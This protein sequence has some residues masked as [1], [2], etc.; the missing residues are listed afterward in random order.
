[1]KFRIWNKALNKFVQPDEWYI[2]GDGKVFFH[3]IM[4]GDLIRAEDGVCVIQRCS[5]VK[6]KNGKEIWEGDIVHYDGG[7]DCGRKYSKAE[8]VFKQGEFTPIPNLATTWGTSIDSR[9]FEVVGNIFE[10]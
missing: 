9:S 5:E 6:D 8:V 10:K 4:D 7:Y 3:D 2:N 1:M